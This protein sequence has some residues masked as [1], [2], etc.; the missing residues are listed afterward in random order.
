MK[1]PEVKV[2]QVGSLDISS[3]GAILRASSGV[4]LIRDGQQF[5]VVD[6]GA[7]EDAPKILDALR[8]YDVAPAEVTLV[9]NTHWH[10]D[11]IGANH[12]FAEARFLAHS[13]EADFNGNIPPSGQLELL[14]STRRVASQT[15]VFP[16]P[17]HTR[18]S[19]SVLVK[20][21]KSSFGADGE[22]IVICG[23]ALPLQANYLKGVPPAH[24]WNRE[25]SCRSINKILAMSDWVIPGHDLP[26]RV[27]EKSIST[28]ESSYEEA[29]GITTEQSCFNAVN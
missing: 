28:K 2:L 12:L 21:A 23:D 7:P 5:I 3:S 19:L 27:G 20:N 13:A 11:H 25:A 10:D 15:E 24:H 22:N 17:G 4:V 9:I 8:L 1:S 6:S 26:F 14:T 16:T 29:Q 18:G